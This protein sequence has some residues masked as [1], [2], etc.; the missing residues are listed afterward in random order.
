MLVKVTSFLLGLYSLHRVLGGVC[1]VRVGCRKKETI[2]DN[3]Q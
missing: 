2:R 1:F 3:P